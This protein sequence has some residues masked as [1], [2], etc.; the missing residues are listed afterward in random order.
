VENRTALLAIGAFINI[1]GAILT[2]FLCGA[3]FLFVIIGEVTW[4]RED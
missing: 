3:G 4:A 2:P 1:A